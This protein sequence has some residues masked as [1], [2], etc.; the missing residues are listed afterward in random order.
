MYNSFVPVGHPMHMHGHE[1]QVL[2]EGFGTWDGVITNPD[3]PTRRDVQFLQQANA[4]DG[5]P[6]YTVLQV[7]LD[8]PA[9]NIFH[10]HL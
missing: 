4:T 1:F 2:A 9:I 5:T 10:C 7:E 6:S 8:N 3:N